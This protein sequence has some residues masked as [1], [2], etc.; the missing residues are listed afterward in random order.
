MKSL[1]TMLFAITAVTVLAWPS[2]AADTMDL[3]EAHGFWAEGP[4]IP[5][6][7]PDEFVLMPWGWTP[8]N[9]K[10][11][12][13]IKECGFNVAGFVAPKHVKLCKSVGISCMVDDPRISQN[14]P[15]TD[16][17]DAE[18][19]KLVTDAVRPFKGNSAVYGYHLIDEP[20]NGLFP[21]LRRW[22]DTIAKV[23]PKTV[24]YINL[25]PV[26]ANLDG[27][28]MYEEFANVVKPTFL[29]YDHYTLHDDGNMGD[30]FYTNLETMRK[31][32][33]KHNLPFWNIVLSNSHFRYADVTVGGMSV[34]VYSSLAYGVR[35]LSYFTYFAPLLDNYRN[36]PVDQFLNKTP[37][38][39]IIRS[40]NLQIHQLAPTYLK[41]KSVNVFHND[42]VPTGC[43]GLDSSKYLADVSGGDFLV[44]EFV[45]PKGEPFVMM[46]NKSITKSTNGHFV[47][48]DKGTVMQTNAFTGV[49]K[50]F[51]GE[52]CWFGPGQGVLFSL[53]K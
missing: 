21:A 24:S 35:G 11:L 29:S 15:R 18:M 53:A 48:K 12:Q 34:Q 13:D 40:L 22:K 42:K 4:N 17:S 52:W 50:P 32:A 8:G 30:S 16:I 45:G 7:S 1:L 25:L 38:W 33:M 47:F 41:L 3:H 51:G 31:V 9:K 37:S 39:D 49:T 19:L 26:G 10:A 23:D 36:A 43:K 44:G 6:L 5:K 27:I 20:S 28:A 2:L 14:I 46:V